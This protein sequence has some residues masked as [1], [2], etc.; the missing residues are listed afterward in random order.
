VRGDAIALIGVG[1][2]G[3]E[4]DRIDEYSDLDFFVVVD[5]GAKHARRASDAVLAAHAGA[6]AE[7][8]VDESLRRTQR[9][10]RGERLAA[11]RL[12]QVHAVDRLR[13]Y[14]DPRR[15]ERRPTRWRRTAARSCAA[16]GSSSQCAGGYERSCEPALAILAWIGRR[17]GP[18]SSALAGRI[19]ELAQG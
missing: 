16:P 5:D 12:I 19:R 3:R 10:A 15:P 14:L 17:R 18:V 1:S 13:T 9:D 6:P 8:G 4:L 7:R 2:V 11:M